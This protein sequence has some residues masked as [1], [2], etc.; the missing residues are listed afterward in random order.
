M[1]TALLCF[2]WFVA[3]GAACLTF[4]AMVNRAWSLD[5]TRPEEAAQHGRIAARAIIFIVLVIVAS[6]TSAVLG[7]PLH[8]QLPPP[9][10]VVN[11][12][13]LLERGATQQR[14][15]LISTITGAALG[16]VFYSQNQTVGTA[17]G[18]IGMGLGIVLQFDGLR[19]QRRGAILLQL[20]YNVNTRYE[21][22][23]DSVDQVTPLRMIP[24]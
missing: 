23:P 8:H 11:G 24:R 5:A 1:N 20:G 17:I 22:V 3:G 13:F 9:G 15:A 7:Q 21:L 10:N 6:I 18:G 14:N 2:L 12:G 4:W 19:A 16:A